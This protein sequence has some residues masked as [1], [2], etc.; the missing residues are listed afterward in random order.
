M[1]VPP[2]P[3][4][5]PPPMR[6]A[7]DVFPPL[8]AVPPPLAVP[9]L[10]RSIELG[11]DRTLYAR[12][13]LLNVLALALGDV[14]ALV[15]AASVASA[16]RHAWLGG[17]YP[18]PV[19]LGYLVPAWLF[20]A[21]LLRLLPGWGLGPVAELRR[22]SILTVTVYGSAMALLFLSQEAEQTSRLTVV[23]A[24]AASWVA[25]P[26]VRVRVKRLLIWQSR[27]G[28]PAAVFGAGP[29]ADRVFRLLKQ[30]R[31]LGYDPVR[32]SEGVPVR[33]FGRRSPARR[34]LPPVAVLVT[35]G[36][37]RDRTAALLEG[38]LARCRSV[39]VVPDLLDTPSLWVRPR[40]LQGV[41]GLEIA[42]N[43]CRPSSR[44]VKRVMDLALTVLAAPLWV[45]LCAVVAALIWLEDRGS[46]FFFQERVGQDARPFHTWK[47]RTM[48][49][50]AEAVLQRSLAAD[51]ALREEWDA[52]YKL[53]E[54]PR[55]TRV[56]AVLRRLS[57]D[58]LPQLFNV[59][60]G[61][62]SLVGPRPLPAYH[63]DALPDRVR[64]LRE[65]VRP[66]IT[67][68]W[69]VS[70]R[71]DIGTDGMK[72]WDPYYVQNWSLWLDAV[73]LFRTARAVASRSGAY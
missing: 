50:D 14:V 18:A 47:F 30:E 55:I 7:D 54:D 23:L 64:S 5:R 9:G 38:P 6:V 35:A 32:P 45:P 20:G 29:A 21:T 62:M 12:R 70:G 33:T 41:L 24:M 40:D 19:W 17:A 71:S 25:V 58:E 69:Q 11:E 1:G 26:L 56:G 51:P 31:G 73:V 15:G 28:V 63:R 48:Y 42:C 52:H 34:A 39:I 61:D 22:I 72:L 36:L 65:R 43:L 27:W 57:L 49:P 37:G 13:H 68:M 4:A 2:R 44:L 46:P 67:G 59:L 3:S 16:L 10:G 60:R 8:E 66:G 53:K